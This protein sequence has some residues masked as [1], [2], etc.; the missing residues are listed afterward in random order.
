MDIRRLDHITIAVRDAEEAA[1]RWQEALGLP[2]V[3]R[4]RDDGGEKIEV[5]QLRAGEVLIELTAPTAADS[6]VQRFLDRRGE[7]VMLLSFRV[8][9]AAA[10]LDELRQRGAPVIDQQPRRFGQVAF[11]FVHP[12]GFNGVLLEFISGS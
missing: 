6:E 12:K 7:G 1:R 8:D 11:G 5:V 9:D 3:G 2:I 4:Y 10:A